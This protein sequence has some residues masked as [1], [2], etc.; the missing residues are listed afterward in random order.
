MAVAT[1]LPAAGLAA[2]GM[3]Y[4]IPA[5]SAFILYRRLRRSFGR[6]PWQ[7]K[8][9]MARMLL[10]AA[11]ACMVMF[12]VVAV[13]HLLPGVALGAVCGLALATLSLRHTDVH[14][15]QGQ[16]SYIPNPWIGGL[17]V[18]VMIARLAWRYAEAGAQ[19]MQ[20]A[21]SPLT[22]GIAA[23]LIAYSLAFAIGVRLQV[24][25]LVSAGS[26]PVDTD[27]QTPGLR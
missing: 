13:P 1:A 23:A 19:G 8:R 9:A 6:Q 20:Q 18:V 3:Q 12:A 15:Y 16:P 17:L 5:L 11:V 2:S 14:W 21:P 7:P 24:R 26:D 10:L 27:T 4:W 25:A 22:F